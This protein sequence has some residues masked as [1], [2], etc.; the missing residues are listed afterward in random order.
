M[1]G[2][3]GAIESPQL[4]NFKF[5]A[6]GGVAFSSGRNERNEINRGEMRA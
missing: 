1:W 2:G 5:C 3:G 4:K 6:R